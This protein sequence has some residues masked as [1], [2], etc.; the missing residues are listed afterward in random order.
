[1][2]GIEEKIEAN[3][4]KG[5]TLR[6]QCAECNRKTRHL[7]LQSM[8]T[9]G[10]EL[11][12]RQSDISLYWDDH[13][14]IVQC[15]GCETISF[16]H[17]NWFS[18]YQDFDSDGST[19]R[20]YPK[21]SKNSLPTKDYFNAPPSLRRIYRETIE[22]FNNE[23]YTLCAAGLRS[24]VEGICED[25][26][27][28]DGPITVTKKDGSSKTERKE[29]LQGKISG[30][31]EKDILTRENSEILHEHRF[32]GNEAVHKLSQPSPEELTLAIEIIEHT[33]DALY[34]IPEKAQE[35]R[36]KKAIRQKRLNPPNPD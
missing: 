36:H 21:R 33:I 2:G 4:T 26:E 13:Y 23:V 1:M 18:E 17:L 25:Q 3:K 24:I 31:C 28:I 12:D 7:V 27:I 34:E 30:L 14:Q 5:E 16:R 10:S 35:L 32:L 11:V 9:S 29:N 22:S 8:D 6:I 15:Q 20:L 19:E